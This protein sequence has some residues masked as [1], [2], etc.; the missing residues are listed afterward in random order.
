MN[1]CFIFTYRTH[2]LKEY[3]PKE[4]CDYSLDNLKKIVK[5]YRTI[6]D[7]GIHKE[8][9]D[10]FCDVVLKAEKGDIVTTD[11]TVGIAHNN[12]VFVTTHERCGGKTLMNISKK[13]TIYRITKES[14][15]G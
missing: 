4:F 8:Y 13:C 10:S 5:D 7:N 12:L 2:P 1:N 6:L 9:F 15:N 11:Q 3:F 14:K